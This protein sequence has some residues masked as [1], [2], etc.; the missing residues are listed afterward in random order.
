[1]KKSQ[2]IE[3]K[4]NVK[5]DQEVLIMTRVGGSGPQDKGRSWRIN[6]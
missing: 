1:M 2:E 5:T 4:D 3:Q 6:K